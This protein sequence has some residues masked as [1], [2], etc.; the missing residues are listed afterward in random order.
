[1]AMIA[2]SNAACSSNPSPEMEDHAALLRRSDELAREELGPVPSGRRAAT[3]WSSLSGF[4]VPGLTGLPSRARGQKAWSVGPVPAQDAA[5][6]EPKDLE[7]PPQR[8]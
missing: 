6:G 1:M 4:L 3:I 8:P 7:V 5:R 2:P